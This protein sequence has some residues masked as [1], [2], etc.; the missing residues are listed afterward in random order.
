VLAL[1][2]TDILRIEQP[3]SDIHLGV[4]LR[5][6]GRLRAVFGLAWRRASVRS[7]SES[8]GISLGDRADDVLIDQLAEAFTD[9]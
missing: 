7:S 4:N 2:Q 1:A 5:M 3:W 8:F 6:I 9:V